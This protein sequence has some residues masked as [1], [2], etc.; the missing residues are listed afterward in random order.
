MAVYISLL[1]GIN[2]GGKHSI[3]MTALAALYREADYTNITTYIQSGNV[4]FE[5]TSAETSKVEAEAIVAEI[6]KRISATFGMNI[7]VI[8]RTRDELRKCWEHNP[9]LIEPD[10]DLKKL[11]VTFLSETPEPENILRVNGLQYPPDQCN[12]NGKEVFVHCPDG[13]GRT[14]LTNALFENILKAQATTRNWNTVQALLKIA[15]RY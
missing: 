15:E 4:V 9:F 5:T 3:S 10:I 13:Y 1:R 2:V 12:L 7:R 11:H 6:E 8:L 14:K